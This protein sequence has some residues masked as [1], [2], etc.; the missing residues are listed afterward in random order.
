MDKTTIAIGLVILV[1]VGGVIYVASQSPSAQAAVGFGP[2]GSGASS[3]AQDAAAV[4]SGIGDLVGGVG[5]AIGSIYGGAAASA[6]GGT[7]STGVA[8]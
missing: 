4:L 8:K 2:A 5:T 7:S 6:A 3:D 1:I